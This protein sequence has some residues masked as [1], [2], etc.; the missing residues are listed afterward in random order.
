MCEPYPHSFRPEGESPDVPGQDSEAV[1]P[2]LQEVPQ[3]PAFVPVLGPSVPFAL[4]FRLISTGRRN[5]VMRIGGFLKLECRG[6]VL[7][8]EA[9]SLT[10]RPGG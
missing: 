9:L 4:R 6:G 8:C 2:F 10:P 3:N 5:D 1:Q 7:A